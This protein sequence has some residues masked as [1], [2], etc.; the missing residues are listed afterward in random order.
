MASSKAWIRWLPD[1]FQEPKPL[2]LNS[3]MTLRV[4]ASLAFGRLRCRIIAAFAKND[5]Q[6]CGN[7]QEPPKTS[8]GE[9]YH[10][11][12]PSPSDQIL[13][14]LDFGAGGS[15]GA[16]DGNRSDELAQNSRR[17]K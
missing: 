16:G 17:Q 15:V 14:T 13:T 4:F 10:T 12:P 9:H 11:H 7:T 8:Y 1:S 5:L 6:S 3:L 2:R